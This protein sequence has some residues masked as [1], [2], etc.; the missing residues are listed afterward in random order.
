VRD[1]ER[2]PAV[3]AEAKK[4]C[5]RKLIPNSAIPATASFA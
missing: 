2:G 4:M 5:A 1:E 3:S